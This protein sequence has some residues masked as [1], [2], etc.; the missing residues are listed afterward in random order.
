MFPR[1]HDWDKLGFLCFLG[2]GIHQ[3]LIHLNIEEKKT[4]QLE[5]SFPTLV[6]KYED[7][8]KDSKPGPEPYID[9]PR[10]RCSCLF[11]NFSE[12]LTWLNYSDTW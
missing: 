11:L 10:N 12:Q 7:P 5:N 1:N 2:C 6:Q 4:T 8:E 3:N 9:L